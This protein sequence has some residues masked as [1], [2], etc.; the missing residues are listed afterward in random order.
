MTGGLKLTRYN[1][2]SFGAKKRQMPKTK[3]LTAQSV[4]G[5]RKR[6]WKKEIRRLYFASA[7]RMSLSSTTLPSKTVAPGPIWH[8]RWCNMFSGIMS[9]VDTRGSTAGG[10]QRLTGVRTVSAGLQTREKPAVASLRNA[11]QRGQAIPRYGI[12]GLAPVSSRAGS[13]SIHPR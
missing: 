1:D 2:G 13:A 6:K 5:K 9:R 3:E 11:L 8:G 4:A 7:R 10:L 12:N